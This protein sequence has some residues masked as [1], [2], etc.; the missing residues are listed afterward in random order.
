MCHI[1]ITYKIKGN[2]CS[3]LRWK[4]CC[5]G[6]LVYE[7]QNK[8]SCSHIVLKMNSEKFSKILINQLTTT[9]YY[10]PRM[11]KCKHQTP[12]KAWWHLQSKMSRNLYELKTSTTF[13]SYLGVILGNITPRTGFKSRL[14]T[15]LAMATNPS[16]FRACMRD[17][18]AICTD[19]KREIKKH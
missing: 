2:C 18:R 12:V 14:Y 9:W 13:T 15:F 17:E 8:V 1:L 3:I 6:C 7:Y 10:H 19:C 5:C 11:E 16:S 4:T